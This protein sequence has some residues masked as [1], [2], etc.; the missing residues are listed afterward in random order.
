MV[1]IWTGDIGAIFVFHL[2][3]VSLIVFQFL[4]SG[5][6]FF[7]ANLYY[8]KHSYGYWL[9]LYLL[10]TPPT[11]THTH[12]NGKVGENLLQHKKMFAVL[13]FMVIVFW[14]HKMINWVTAGLPLVAHLY[15]Y[16]YTVVLFI[17]IMLS[18]RWNTAFWSDISFGV[19][20]RFRW[21]LCH[22]NLTIV[23][24]DMV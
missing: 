22:F 10:W 24:I 5:I 7:C 8:V 16:I 6:F 23:L 18:L 2:F 11:P 3:W 21:N 17:Q 13:V 14:K 15:K 20:N 1:I 12:T 4:I 9:L 19:L